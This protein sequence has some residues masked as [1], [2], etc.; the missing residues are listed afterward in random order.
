[1]VSFETVLSV[2]VWGSV[3]AVIVAAVACVLGRWH[4]AARLARAITFAG[5]VLL[6]LNVLV[7]VVVPL[8]LHGGEPSVKATVL[9][10]GISEAMNCGGLAVAAAILAAG[11]WAL[12]R[13]RLRVGRRSAG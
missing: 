2:A 5:P 9:S 11:T 4:F 12:A 10:Q 1:M 7:F 13:W 3:V 8:G 6:A